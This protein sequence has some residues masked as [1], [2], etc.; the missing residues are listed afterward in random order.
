M[1]NI[2]KNI[3]LS[4]FVLSLFVGASFA[5]VNYYFYPHYVITGVVTADSG[6]SPSGKPVVFFQNTDFLNAGIFVSSEAS[7][8]KYVLNAYAAVPPLSYFVLMGATYYVAI[9]NS[10]PSS[11]SDG[12]GADP[13]AVSISGKG[14]EIANLYYKKGGGGGVII[15]KTGESPLFDTI[16]FGNRVYQKSLVARGEKF[17]VSATPKISA[18]VKSDYGID[19]KALSININE[20][21]G[22]ASSH[23]FAVK[24]VDIK[25]VIK[26]A[27]AAEGAESIKM[28]S[29]SYDVPSAYKLSEG[30]NTIKLKAS[31]L[32]GA[33]EEVAI[34]TVMSGPLSVIGQVL[35]YP[36]PFSPTRDKNVMITYTLSGDGDI[37]IILVSGGKQVVKKLTCFAGSE[38]GSA[39]LNKVY[40]DG[41]PDQG[42]VVGNGI[43]SGAI[44]DKAL[45]K[46]LAR[47]KLSVVD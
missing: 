22:D 11:P 12:Y 16:K 35:T 15:G 21:R 46:I 19:T 30:Q 32:Y 39:G 25:S 10:N 45:G 23:S 41:K 17:I 3:I 6:G 42:G 14:K 8:N 31:N 13:V 4:L 26:S 36:S 34:V 1:R 27:A 40:W 28:L 38:G 7:S 5:A 47:F 29:F 33:T 9:P 20:E 44:I 18:T 37:D 43:Y 24:E 2:F